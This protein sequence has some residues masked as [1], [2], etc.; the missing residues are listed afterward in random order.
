M[1]QYNV[2]KVTRSQLMMQAMMKWA[3]VMIM[4]RAR[5]ASY[6]V[7]HLAYSGAQKCFECSCKQGFVTFAFWGCLF[8]FFSGLPSLRHKVEREVLRRTCNRY[9]M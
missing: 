3:T 8:V 1:A 4:M 9:N 7:T 2:W 5:L 6:L